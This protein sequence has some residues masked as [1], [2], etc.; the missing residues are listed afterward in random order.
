LSQP[1]VILDPFLL[2]PLVKS[3]LVIPPPVLVSL[4]SLLLQG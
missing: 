3:A 1:L 4:T 2:P